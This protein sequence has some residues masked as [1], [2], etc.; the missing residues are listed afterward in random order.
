MEKLQFL[1]NLLLEYYSEEELSKI[2]K[3]YNSIR[4][5]TFRVNKLKASVDEIKQ[6]LDNEKISYELVSWYPDAFVI[7][8]S[9][10]IQDYSIYKEGKIYLQSLSSMMPVLFLDLNKNDSVL[11]MAASP[12]GKTTQIASITNDTVLIT[13]VEKNKIRSERLKYNIDMQGV[14]RANV[15]QCDARRIEDYFKFDK[16]LLDAPCSGSGTLNISDKNIEEVFTL[17]LVDRSVKTQKELL[18][19]AVKLLKKDGILVYSTCSILKSENEENVKMI[20][21]DNT[22]ELV[23]IDKDLFDGVDLLSTTIDGV[24]CVCPSE[25]YEGFFIAKF[26]KK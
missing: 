1:N 3:G 8:S 23:P 17:E 25:V 16:I 9:V 12:G 18:K 15:M 11:D 21:E 5:L 22:M 13:A 6:F 26:R 4:S 14:R 24:I 19:K 7:K 2:Y 20:L 10:R